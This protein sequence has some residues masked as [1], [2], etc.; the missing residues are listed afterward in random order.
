MK[1]CDAIRYSSRKEKGLCTK[2]ALPSDGKAQCSA[3]LKNSRSCKKKA[4]L[5]KI[6]KGLCTVCPAKAIPNRVYC[7]DCTV[8]INGKGRGYQLT[9]VEKAAMLSAQGGRC[10]ICDKEPSGTSKHS[11]VLHVDHCHQTGA[12]RGML[13]IGCNARLATL[14]N[15]N[16]V[17]KANAY[18]VRT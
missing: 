14:E 7:P 10:A 8:K 4:R 13:C 15:A 16:W 5:E 2:C 6:S 17:A 9:A 3:C 18:L 1:K 11:S 12:V